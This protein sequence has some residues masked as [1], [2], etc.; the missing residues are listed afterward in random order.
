MRLTR[1]N[2][3]KAFAGFSLVDLTTNSNLTRTPLAPLPPR[4]SVRHSIVSEPSDNSAG[5]AVSDYVL[6]YASFAEEIPAWGSN[7]R[8][9]D[10]LLRQFWPT[11][12]ILASAI[13][14][15][16]ARY[17]AFGWQLKGPERMVSIVERILHGSEH[18]QGWL[19]FITKILT[20]LF[21]QDNGAFFEI[22]RGADDPTSPVLSLKHLDSNRCIRT[23]RSEQPVIY[24]DDNNQG[25]KLKYY[26]VAMLTEFPSP[27]ETMR[28]MQYCTV[29]RLLRASQIIKDIQTY[30]REKLSGRN[31]GAIHLVSGVQSKTI[32]DVLTTRQAA[33]DAQ[34]LTRYMRPIIIASLDPTKQVSKETI[35]IASLPDGF[36]EDTTLKWYI[37]QLALAFGADYQDFAPLP[38]GNLGSAQQSETLH[39]KSRGK[40]PRLFMSMIEHIFNFHGVLP[41]SVRF[42]FGDQDVAED[43]QHARMRLLHAQ[44][45][46][47]KIKSGEISTDMARRLAVEMG[48]MDESYL[49][50]PNL[51]TEPPSTAGGGFSG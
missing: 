17:A 40:G 32:E 1:R 9:R 28:G 3:L 29:T 45:R 23:G 49:E 41:R 20:D 5:S 35:E 6:Y 15:T 25:H 4:S 18:G 21:T 16:T 26:Q 14:T 2:L 51:P 44:E 22:I 38:G 50:L 36:D 27:I 39:L 7:P 10:R 43:T 19:P 13:F 8:E 42:I 37:S 47:I 12:P 34:G 30:K 48:D 31:T 11:E 24:Y 33:A 46:S